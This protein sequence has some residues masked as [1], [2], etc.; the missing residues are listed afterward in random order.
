[1]INK[2]FIQNLK[3]NHQNWESQRRQII[4]LSNIVLHDSKRVIFTLHRGDKAGAEKSLEEIE[5]IIKNLEK[6][7]GQTRIEAEGAYKAGVEEY[8]EAKMLYLVLTGKSLDKIK[9]INLNFSW[10]SSTIRSLAFSIS[11]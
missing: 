3:K 9:G 6:K 5:K 10:T 4:S 1:M 11:L 8:V 2:K 7:F